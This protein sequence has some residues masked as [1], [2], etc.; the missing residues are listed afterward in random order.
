MENMTSVYYSDVFDSISPPTSRRA[1]QIV[2]LPLA[3]WPDPTTV[4]G[5]LREGLS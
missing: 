2:S 5:A 3:L 4:S 1:V